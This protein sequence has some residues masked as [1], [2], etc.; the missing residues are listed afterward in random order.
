MAAGLALLGGLAAPASAAPSTTA[1]E[2]LLAS[3][4]AVKVM[5]P[6]GSVQGLRLVSEHGNRDGSITSR[7][8]SD[9]GTG[10]TYA[11][12]AGVTVHLRSGQSSHG[13]YGSMTVTFPKTS[14]KPGSASKLVRA[15]RSAGRSTYTDALNAGIP[16]AEANAKLRKFRPTGGATAY[17]MSGTYYQS[18]CLQPSNPRDVRAVWGCFTRNLLQTNGSDWYVGDDLIATENPPVILFP[19]SLYILMWYGAGNT[20]VNYTPAPGG[21]GCKQATWSGQLGFSNTSLTYSE[22]NNICSGYTAVIHDAAHWGLSWIDNNSHLNLPPQ[23]TIE[24]IGVVHSPPS[25]SIGN[26]DLELA[27]GPGARDAVACH[28]PSCH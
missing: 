15:Y 18:G 3:S 4:K 23:E 21:T 2:H 26:S 14:K 8:T 10:F 17:S 5:A 9:N 7:W 11:G 1:A 25:A 24:E 16:R 27:W 6:K 19:N 12:T 20:V 13:R 28:T 22:T